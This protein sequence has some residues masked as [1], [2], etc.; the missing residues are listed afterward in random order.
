MSNYVEMAPKHTEPDH[1]DRFLG[2][3]HFVFPDL[4]LEVEGIVDRIGGLNR[5]INRTLDETLAEIGLDTA[6]YKALTV[7]RSQARRSAARPAGWRSGWSSRA[8]R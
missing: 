7:C 3:I 5:R 4:D 2:K 1:I 8:A 6:E